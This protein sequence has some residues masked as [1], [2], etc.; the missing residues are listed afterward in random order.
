[1]ATKEDE[2]YE[3]YLHSVGENVR[4]A[5]WKAG[6]TQEQAASGVVAFRIL[7]EIERGAANPTLQTL[8]LL[9]RKLGV[10]VKDLVETGGEQPLERPLRELDVA[11]P[12]RGRKPKQ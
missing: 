3:H 7:T 8:F 5:R 12:K 1:M 10:S 2:E 9:A 4:K 6:L 11:S